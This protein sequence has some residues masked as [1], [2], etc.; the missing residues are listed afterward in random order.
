[1][2]DN[3]HFDNSSLVHFKHVES[4]AFVFN[5]FALSWELSLDFEQ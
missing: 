2:N 4:E 3:L 5:A 1:M